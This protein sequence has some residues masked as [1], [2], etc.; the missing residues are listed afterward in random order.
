MHK[1]FF[2][3]VCLLTLSTTYADDPKTIAIFGYRY[4]ELGPWDPDTVKT[5]LPGSEEAV[6]YMAKQLANLG[7]K[8]VVLAFPPKD[9]KHSLPDANPRYVDITADDG[10]HYDIAIS[11]RQIWLGAKLR[12]R[13]NLIYLWP[14]DFNTMAVSPP[15]VNSY[16]G[17]LWLSKWQRNQW[18][19]TQPLFEKFTPIFGNGVNPEQFQPI[20]K[21]ENSYACIY[22]SSYLRGLDVLLDVWPEIKTRFPRASLDIYYGWQHYSSGITP[23]YVL[24]LQKKLTDSIPLDV[25]EHGCVGHDELTKANEK[26]SLWTYP[27]TYQETFCITGLRAQFAGAVPVII[28]GSALEETV[29]NGFICSKRE[30]YLKNLI[31]AMSY[32]DKITEEDRNHMRSFILKDYTWERLAQKWSEEFKAREAE[33][34]LESAR[35]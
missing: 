3:F 8:V 14:H 9:S 29:Q 5:G 28:N 12:N 31:E 4:E 23:D 6:V 10:A 33:K 27:C 17:V 26:A 25:H 1:I 20:A 22:A 11:L 21:R 35:F 7:Y 2:F 30:E 19:S 34:K 18:I 24:N 16:D 13:A 32:A 15:Q